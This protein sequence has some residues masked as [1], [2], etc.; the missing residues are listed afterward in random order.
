MGGVGE[1]SNTRDIG[2]GDCDG[3]GWGR[4]LIRGAERRGERRL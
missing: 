3:R 4:R 2:E 1:E